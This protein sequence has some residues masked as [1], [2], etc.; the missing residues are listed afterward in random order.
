MSVLP[1]PTRSSVSRGLRPS[2]A[3]VRAEG[4]RQGQVVHHVAVARRAREVD[5]DPAASAAPRAQRSTMAA[6]PLELV[7]GARAHRE[8]ARGVLGDDVHRLAA[9]GDEAVHP[10]AVAEVHPLRVDELKVWRHAV[11]ALAPSHG[12]AAA[13]DGLPR[14]AS[15]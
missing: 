7:E 12:A 5:L 2:A 6:H 13:C 11:R 15:W 10:H 8:L 14:E 4:A 3:S 1:A 9:V